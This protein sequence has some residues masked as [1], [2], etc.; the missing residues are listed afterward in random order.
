MSMMKLCII[1]IIFLSLFW[2]RSAP[3]LP[4]FCIRNF[5]KRRHMLDSGSFS[6]FYLTK[7]VCLYQQIKDICYDH[8]L[9]LSESLL[10]RILELCEDNNRDG[11]YR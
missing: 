6:F 5:D 9:P 1:C 2:G 4:F 8:K 10:N 11:Q 3:I 7:I